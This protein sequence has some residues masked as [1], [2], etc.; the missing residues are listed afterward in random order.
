MAMGANSIG[1]PASSNNHFIVLKPASLRCTF[2][3]PRVVGDPD[4]E[5]RSPVVADSPPVAPRRIQTGQNPPSA[6]AKNFVPQIG[7]VRVSCCIDPG[8]L[9][10]SSTGPQDSGFTASALL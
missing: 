3:L 5:P 4:T 10:G 2:R 8:S 9:L 7:Q 6:V 1:V